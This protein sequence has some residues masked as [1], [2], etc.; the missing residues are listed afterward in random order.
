MVKKIKQP[1]SKKVKFFLLLSAVWL[2]IIYAIL[3]SD[4]LVDMTTTFL[5]VGILP[6]LIGWGV[7]WIKK[8]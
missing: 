3:A 7:Y 1:K 8:N 2:L 6:V 4:P 5:V